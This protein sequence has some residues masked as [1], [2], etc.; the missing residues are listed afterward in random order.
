MAAGS[1]VQTIQFPDNDPPLVRSS[2]LRA[3]AQ[4][5]TTLA[6]QVNQ[7]NAV[8]GGSTNSLTLYPYLTYKASPQLP[9]SSLL[10]VISPLV[11]NGGNTI[12]IDEALIM[13]E[14]LG[15]VLVTGA[16]TGQLLIWNGLKWVNVSPDELPI[17]WSQIQDTPTT[18]S[19]YGITD[20]V[21]KNFEILTGPGLVGG[22]P[23]TGSSLVIG[24]DLPLPASYIQGIPVFIPED[25]EPN[26]L[27]IPGPPG[28]PGTPGL[29]G[30]P[31]P[32][33]EDGEDGETVVGPPG[34]DGATGPPGA[35]GTAG[36]QGPPGQ[37]GEEG[38]DGPPGP[39]G[40]PGA[41]G[42]TGATGA[43][44]PAL[45]MLATDGE[46]G[47][48]GPP[49]QPG[50]PGTA[51]SPGAA[52]SPGPPGPPG[53]DGED[54]E[55]GLPGIPGNTGPQ[56][57]T[58]AQGAALFM[59]ATDGED[60]ADGRPG[61]SV[62]GPQGIQGPAG[63][64]GTTLAMQWP[65][66]NSWD[67][68]VFIATPTNVSGKVTQTGIAPQMNWPDENPMDEPIYGGTGTAASGG[69]ASFAIGTVIYGPSAPTDG[70]TWLQCNGQSVSQSTYATLYGVVGQN[71]LQYMLTVG[72]P[73]A[74]MTTA[75]KC[76][77]DGTD[78]IMV[79]PLG[80]SSWYSS[81]GLTWTIGGSPPAAANFPS[82]PLM[83]SDGAGNVLVWAAASTAAFYTANH[84]V[85]WSAVTL[86]SSGSW[87]FANNGANWVGI[88]AAS[89]GVISSST[90]GA[91][92]T[93]TASVLPVTPSAINAF[94]FDGTQWNIFSTLATTIATQ[95]QTSAV[96]A[97]TSGWSNTYVTSIGLTPS[98]SP[99]LF[100]S[101][102]TNLLAA[103]NVGERWRYSTNSGSSFTVV[104]S[105]AITGT[106]SSY[107][108]NGLHWVNATA[109]TFLTPTGNHTSFNAEIL[110]GTS[111][112]PYVGNFS[113]NMVSNVSVSNGAY[114][115]QDTTNHRTVGMSSQDLTGSGTFT[116]KPYVLSPSI[117]V[118]TNF[119]VPDM[120]VV[121][122][123]TVPKISDT[124][125]IKAL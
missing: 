10:Q 24:L 123:T 7:N 125:W 53:E 85:S 29:Q 121:P 113:V 16:V 37:D 102:S 69:G 3:L 60:G 92:F 42:A 112:Y 48:P 98:S 46:D 95:N 78:W 79:L 82:G 97:G 26:D 19:G 4:T 96:A 66:E 110:A 115:Q 99:V 35:D 36:S 83:Y 58:G 118:S 75:C 119:L 91:A 62:V 116:V 68:Q 9:N 27:V 80:V 107:Q 11:I 120:S 108:W 12:G 34:Q 104:S 100:I 8:Q 55:Q 49:G 2:K 105:L 59:L 5:V 54:G 38:E 25:P 1:L 28:I 89:T 13:L 18:L 64:T 70:G 73:L 101:G 56:G 81:D 52:G 50:I 30:P 20:G 57:N 86:P 21:N 87:I 71:Y 15:D 109:T 90:S 103:Y 114:N 61:A 40:I 17:L 31:G 93:A 44:G 39:P 106:S 51:G 41:D 45:F 76:I 22:G 63:P 67:D 124:A 33:G 14:D 117:T 47:D 72:T 32:P 94:W 65:D 111:S 122:G 23:M 43:T 84:G 74:S 77:F 6:Q 88:K